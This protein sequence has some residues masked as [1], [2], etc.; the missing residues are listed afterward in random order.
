MV[1]P[2]LDSEM[3][4]GSAS[5]ASVGRG[6]S[7]QNL[8]CSE[9]SRWPGDGAETLA[10]LKAALVPDGEMV[11]ESTPNGAYGA[12]YDE[13][14]AGIDEAGE[15]EALVRHFFPWWLEERYVGP[16]VSQ[17][18]MGETEIELVKRSG[19]SE[20]Q[21][22]FRRGLQKSFGAL[23]SQE[24]AEDAVS[25]FRA[26]G[27]CCFDAEALERR[28]AELGEPAERR[29]NGALWV[30]LAARAAKEYIVAVDS[31]GGG[32]DGDF[33]AVQVI[34]VRTGLQCAELRERLGPAETAS[35]AAELAREYGGAMVAVERNNHG[36]AVL[37]YL[38]TRERYA[39]LYE[40]G[41]ERGW[42]TSSATRPEMI[43]RLRVLLEQAPG[44]FLSRRLL[45]ECR[46]FVA[47]RDGRMSAAAG[48][49]DDL[50]MAMG[51]AQAVREEVL[52]ASR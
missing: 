48:S 18:A 44:R 10:G 39:R 45:E 13:W 1:F 24:F 25:C 3:C 22:G 36:S 19:L 27:A 38:E 29:R 14:R 30:W 4:V 6:V 11:L 47:G 43:A 21:I 17:A 46:T 50:V 32:A 49:H 23:R 37:A 42:L 16:E 5:D 20:A 40:S 28:L 7:L 26:S 9:V 8:H 31:A 52:S 51:I 33:A 35:V 41:G 34:E 12:F 2:E 15:P